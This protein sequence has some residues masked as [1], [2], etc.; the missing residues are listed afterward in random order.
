MLQ[1]WSRPVLEVGDVSYCWQDVVLLALLTGRWTPLARGIREGLACIRHAEET[2]AEE[3]EQAIDEFAAE[4]RYERD[5]ITAQETEAWLEERKLDTAAWMDWARREVLRRE[6]ADQ[7]EEL[8]R[9]YP[10]SPADIASSAAVDLFCSSRGRELVM[11]LAQRVAANAALEEAGEAAGDALPLQAADR[12]LA[13]LPGIDPADALPRLDLLARLDRGY[14]RFRAIAPTRELIHRELELGRL[15]W[16]R[17]DCRVLQFETEAL[18]REAVF[19]VREDGLG[20]D[21]VAE[22]AHALVHEMRFYLGELDPDLQPRM[23][24][25]A[26][27]ELVGPVPFEEGYALFLILEKLLPD[28]NAPDLRKEIERRAVARAVTDQVNR[29]VRWFER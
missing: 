14:A 24:A 8:V 2:G 7:L 29:R 13:Q 16:I 6:W 26:P 15:E 11:D 18:A 28:E 23:L 1:L 19:C 20:V 10:S 22:S 4:F 5:L 21:E 9:R 25:A 27:Q 17:I 12:I 3:P